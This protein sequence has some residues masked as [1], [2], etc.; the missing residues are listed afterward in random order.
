MPPQKVGGQ[1]YPTEL[2][3]GGGGGGAALC[4][5]LELECVGGA[6]FPRTRADFR[7]KLLGAN[8]AGLPHRSELLEHS[9][10]LQTTSSIWRWAFIFSS[11]GFL[12]LVR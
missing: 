5:D 6:V 8:L 3:G 4:L 10:A 7:E 9:G 2:G 11:P 12:F 1:L